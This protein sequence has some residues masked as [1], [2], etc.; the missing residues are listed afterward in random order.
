MSVV[1]LKEIVIN[2]LDINGGSD[3]VV[4]LLLTGEWIGVSVRVLG[5]QE[6]TLSSAV[7]CGNNVLCSQ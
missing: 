6:E 2:L 4:S 7:A 3:T 5:E 1:G